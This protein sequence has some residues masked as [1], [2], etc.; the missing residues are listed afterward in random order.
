MLVFY[1]FRIFVIHCFF[2]TNNC[3]AMCNR[4]FLSNPFTVWNSMACRRDAKNFAKNILVPSMHCSLSS[5]AWH[6]G[7]RLGYFRSLSSD[8][9]W[10]HKCLDIDIFACQLDCDENPNKMKLT[11]VCLKVWTSVV[12]HI[13]TYVPVSR[14][15]VKSTIR[16]W[17]KVKTWL[18]K[19]FWQIYQNLRPVRL[20]RSMRLRGL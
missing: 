14:Y 7:S 16:N 8:W 1:Y 20:L 6:Y 12:T 18:D 2:P 11:I 19:M 9:Y 17:D 10:S 3:Y 15:R 4:K 13:G 5:H